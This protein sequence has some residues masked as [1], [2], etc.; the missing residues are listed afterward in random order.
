MVESHFEIGGRV[1][2][3]A[4]ARSAGKTI[5]YRRVTERR[6]LSTGHLSEGNTEDIESIQGVRRRVSRRQVSDYGGRLRLEDSA[7][8]I[9]Q[10]DLGELTPKEGDQVVVSSSESWTVLWGELRA[11]GSWKVY[12]R[13]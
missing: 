4:R 11:D 8:V 1:A 7:W 10:D 9:H 5:T 12:A 13:R 2:S 3:Q 6:A